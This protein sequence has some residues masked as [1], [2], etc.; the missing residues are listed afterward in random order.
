MEV[1]KLHLQN[2]KK[3][4]YEA[5]YFPVSLF[6]LSHEFNSIFPEIF[7]NERYIWLLLKLCFV[8]DEK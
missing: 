2:L 6:K 8:V 4:Q 1:M 5:S 3:K 7:Q